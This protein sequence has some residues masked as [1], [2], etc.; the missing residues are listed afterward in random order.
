M[1]ICGDFRCY[2]VFCRGM[3]RSSELCRVL[4]GYA[5]FGELMSRLME[6]CG[7]KLLVPRESVF[8]G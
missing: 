4:L 5:A 1:K 7:V 3:R 8:A 2:A 6:F